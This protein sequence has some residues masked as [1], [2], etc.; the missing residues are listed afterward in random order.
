[1]KETIVRIA[2]IYFAIA[3]VIWGVNL[4]RYLRCKYYHAFYI[5]NCTN[6]TMD[7]NYDVRDS[8]LDLYKKSQIMPMRIADIEWLSDESFAP[9]VDKIFKCIEG[10]FKYRSRGA[11]AWF[12]SAIGSFSMFAYARK[13]NSKIISFLLSL[14]GVIGS[15]AVG[16]LCDATGFGDMLDAFS[17]YLREWVL[18]LLRK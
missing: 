5:Q 10:R 18:Q 9:Y 14:L 2:I 7:K 12:F 6:H 8:I 1:M 13:A 15:Y 11:F 4:V 16:R 3:A 17:L